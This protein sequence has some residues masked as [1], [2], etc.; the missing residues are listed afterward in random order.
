MKMMQKLMLPCKAA[1]GLMEKKHSGELSLLEKI[2]L[3]FHTKMCEAC[4]RYEEQSKLIE[5]WFKSREKAPVSPELEQPSEELEERIL[6][7]LDTQH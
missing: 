2:Q 6:Q 3:H 7:R 1:T 4:R 5:R